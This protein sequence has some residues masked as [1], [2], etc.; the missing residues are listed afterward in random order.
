LREYGQ[1]TVHAIR[2][3]IHFPDANVEEFE[4]NPRLINKL[5]KMPFKGQEDEN[6]MHHLFQYC[7]LCDMLGPKKL[8]KEFRYLKLFRWSL[9]DKAFD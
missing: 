7:T 1:S 4:I 5:R 9:K 6:R 3:P 8:N 2:K